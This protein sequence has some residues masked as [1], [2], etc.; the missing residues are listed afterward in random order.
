M[1]GKRKNVNALAENSS[2]IYFPSWIYD[3]LDQGDI[4]MEDVTE[5]E[6]EIAKK[7]VIDSCI[8]VHPNEAYCLLI[9]LR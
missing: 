6:K 5:E 7:M 3:Q 9:V 2:Q 4:E 8:M 1:A